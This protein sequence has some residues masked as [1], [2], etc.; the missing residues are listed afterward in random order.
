MA[1]ANGRLVGIGDPGPCHDMD[2]TVRELRYL[3]NHGFVGVA[4]PVPVYDP[5]MPP[6]SAPYY[7]P[8]WAACAELGLVVDV[9]AG[10]GLPQFG[11][12][13]DEL[14]AAL[15][16]MPV[17]EAFK[18]LT[19]GILGADVSID[20]FPKDSPVRLG[21]T[22]PRRV[23]WQLILGGVLDRHPSL[24]VALT[25]MRADWIP[26]TLA[27]LEE[28]FEENG[29]R[30]P[31]SPREYWDQHFY[32]TPSSPRPYE[33]ALRGQ[34][35]LTKMMFG[36][37]YPHVESTWPTT[38][39]WIRHA[40]AGVPE[41]EARLVLGENAIECYGLDRNKLLSVAAKIG[42]QPDEILGDKHVVEEALVATFHTRSGYQRP[43]EV[44]DRPFY[45][46][47]INED[48]DL[49]RSN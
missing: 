27:V 2:E 15:E 39:E 36:M 48:E 31:K 37:D 18:Q 35:G 45:R 1:D 42:P 21:I 40:F 24:K 12:V 7:E 41:Q 9:H 33:I 43:P 38:R 20:Q 32:V 19:T 4:P 34:I 22:A 14:K 26:A 29:W 23:I 30:L 10:Y 3:A 28:Y 16:T 13:P 47:M 11:G 25:E 49:A 44:L 5:D 17:E 6:L 8:F 46:E